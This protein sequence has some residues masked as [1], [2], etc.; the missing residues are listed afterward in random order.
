MELNTT[1]GL[2]D[3]KEYD[4]QYPNLCKLEDVNGDSET[5]DRLDLKRYFCP[6]L[7]NFKLGGYW[8]S[9]KVGYVHMAYVKCNPEVE[10]RRNITCATLEEKNKV[11]GNSFFA[12]LINAQ[13]SIDPR[14]F[15][16]PISRQLQYTFQAIDERYLKIRRMF[17][18]PSNMITDSGI[19]FQ[20]FSSEFFLEETSGILD[21]TNVPTNNYVYDNL[22]YGGKKSNVYNRSYVKV[23]SVAAVV[24]GFLQIARI[25][26]KICYYFYFE[27]SY[28]K[29]FYEKLFTLVEDDGYYPKKISTDVNSSLFNRTHKQLE[30]PTESITGNEIYSRVNRP[31]GLNNIKN[32]N[33]SSNIRLNI[34]KSFLKNKI[35]KKNENISEITKSDIFKFNFLFKR[36]KK[37]FF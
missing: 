3:T 5:Y 14:N 6:Q 2:Y 18:S 10:K 1:T 31:I 11:W 7:K 37:S 9:N 30:L 12:G 16:N 17:Y 23:Q 33:L 21:F 28:K 34:E 25:I 20:E 29:Y 35:Y 4:L 26:L 15:T 24:G 19:I 13:I 32:N 36:K 27:S 22:F 8:D